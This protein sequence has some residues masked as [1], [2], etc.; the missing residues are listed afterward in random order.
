M[1]RY[2]KLSYRFGAAVFLLS[3]FCCLFLDMM[4]DTHYNDFDYNLD[5]TIININDKLYI[6]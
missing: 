6:T 5:N 1:K 2:V 4:C 3:I